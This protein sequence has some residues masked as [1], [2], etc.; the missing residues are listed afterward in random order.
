MEYTYLPQAAAVQFD[1][2]TVGASNPVGS[3]G[4]TLFKFNF[5][6]TFIFYIIY[7]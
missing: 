6:L 1:A 5:K 7:N 4:E 3:S 2:S